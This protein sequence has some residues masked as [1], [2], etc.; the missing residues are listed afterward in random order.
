MEVFRGDNSKTLHFTGLPTW[1]LLFCLYD[2]V[3]D[4]L[5]NGLLLNGFQKLLLTLMSMKLNLYGT[6]LSF[7]FGGISNSTVSRTFNH[8]FNHLMP[9]SLQRTSLTHPFAKFV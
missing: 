6:D 2:F 7:R 5:D 1:Q 4:Y 9:N 3:K 8:S